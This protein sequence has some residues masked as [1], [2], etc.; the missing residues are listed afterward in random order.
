VV[1]AMEADRGGCEVVGILPAWIAWK[2]LTAWANPAL[3]SLQLGMTGR[4]GVWPTAS[5]ERCHPTSG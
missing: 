5:P 1:G 2:G 4:V 3:G